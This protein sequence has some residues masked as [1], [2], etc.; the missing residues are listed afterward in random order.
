MNESAVTSHVRLEAA[1]RGIELWRNNSGG[2]YDDKGRFVRYGLGS[3]TPQQEC[4]SS[5]F[6]GITPVLIMPHHVGHVVGVFTAVEMKHEGWHLT[7]GDK[8]GLHQKKFID[9]VL[10]AGGYAGFAKDIEDFRR[11]VKHD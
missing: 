2:F 9:M 10:A 3:F 11:I 6:I 1:N 7:P 5:D 4:K 8:R